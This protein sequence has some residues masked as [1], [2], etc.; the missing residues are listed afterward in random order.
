MDSIENIEKKLNIR[1]TIKQK[2]ILANK[3]MNKYV[4]PSSNM[5]VSTLLTKLNNPVTYYRLSL[6]LCKFYNSW[7]FATYT[8]FLLKNKNTKDIEIFEKLF[9]KKNKKDSEEYSKDTIAEYVNN[10]IYNIDSEYKF[11]NY[12]DIGC[13]NGLFT[14]SFGNIIGAKKIIGADIP[15]EFE[16]GWKQQLDLT[17]IEF[18]EIKNNKLNFKKETFD[19]ISCFM[20]LHHIDLKYLNEY[21]LTIF[22][23]LTINGIF[24]I[25]EHDCIN[26]VDFMIADLEHSLFLAQKAKSITTEVKKKIAEQIIHYKNRFEWRLLI[27]SFGFKCIYEEPYD[28]TPYD[29]YRPNRAYI[30]IFKK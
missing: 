22:K 28:T 17:G 6:L 23:I 18:Y 8:Y 15:D 9:S 30:A 14:K 26:A 16:I 5:Q 1:F 2:K 11:N 24:I 12:L 7:D 25:K 27:E 20:V 10:I 19:I 13:G 21:I 3:Q 29:T 4:A